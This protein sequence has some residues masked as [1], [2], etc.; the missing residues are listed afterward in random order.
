VNLDSRNP[1]GT[2]VADDVR[3]GL[4][5]R[6]KTLPP[7]LFYDEAGSRLYE[8]ITEL[9]EYY[10]TRVERRLLS[11]HARDIVGYAGASGTLT[12]IELGAG[13]ASKTEL[14]LRAT[15]ER[16]GRCTYFPIDVSTGALAAA[17]RR[18]RE[19]LPA[20]DVRALPASYES[21]LQQLGSVPSP[22]LVLFI[23]SSVGNMT[24]DQA[25][26]L[27]RCIR[28]SL[29][30]ETWLLL[31]TD[32]RKNPDVLRTAYDDVAGVTSA[33]NKNLLTRINRELGAHFD[34][35]RFRHVARWNG[36]ASCVEMHLESTRDQE[37]RVDDLDLRVPFRVG[38]TIHTESCAKYDLPRVEKLLARGGF[39]PAAVYSDRE[40]DFAVHLAMARSGGEYD[41]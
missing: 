38:E 18:L 13:S 40:F 8:R 28:R 23:G 6:P 15:L 33:F 41:A 4:T 35:D 7:Y 37:V 34:L 16:Q 17:Q 19:T 32:L 5:A 27:L 2:R 31:G 24:D 26:A 11:S 14:L 20:V 39:A 30:G 22:R 9:P 10:L 12:L 36:D 21:G 29:R 3:R 1:Q 25:S